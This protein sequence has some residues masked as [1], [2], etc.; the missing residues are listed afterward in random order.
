[1]K[2][3]WLLGKGVESHQDVITQ[4]QASVL[5]VCTGFPKHDCARGSAV[6]RCH[7]VNMRSMLGL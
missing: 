6:T 7:V 3:V 1:M 2:V 5:Y 4:F